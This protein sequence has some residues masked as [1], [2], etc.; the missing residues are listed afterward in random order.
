MAKNIGAISDLLGII[1]D[2]IENYT[3][4]RNTNLLVSTI[5]EKCGKKQGYKD[6]CCA[7][8]IIVLR[9]KNPFVTP[10]IYEMNA[11]LYPC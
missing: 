5:Y 7:V 8:S 2:W 3:K 10:F 11:I 1:N 6:F 9:D 4:I